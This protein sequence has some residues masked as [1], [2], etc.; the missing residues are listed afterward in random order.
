[1][2]TLGTY[3]LGT[4]PDIYVVPTNCAVTLRVIITHPAHFVNEYV[5][6][7][8]DMYVF[9]VLSYKKK[10]VSVWLFEVWFWID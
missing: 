9:S 5:K 4:F 7:F 6:N 2:R 8:P 3:M 10:S 1:M